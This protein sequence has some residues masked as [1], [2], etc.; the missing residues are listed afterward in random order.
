MNSLW[1]N[2]VMEKGFINDFLFQPISLQSPNFNEIANRRNL[3]Q[4]PKCE[5][6]WL[7]KHFEQHRSYEIE[8]PV[9]LLAKNH[10]FFPHTSLDPRAPVNLL[11][12]Y[13]NRSIY[14]KIIRKLGHYFSSNKLIY[15][16]AFHIRENSIFQI[17]EN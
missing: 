16:Y 3:M 10:T 7:L 12:I 14:Q 4:P 11:I 2:W 1:I 13:W 9:L 5:L 8:I 6:A 15:V 17:Q